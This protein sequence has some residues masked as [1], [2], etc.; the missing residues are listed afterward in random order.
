[1]TKFQIGKAGITSGVVEN[2]SVY[3]KKNKVARISALKS[4]ER[5]REKIKEI[6]DELCEKLPGN[7]K[8]TIVGFT[9]ILRR[10]GEVKR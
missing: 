10:V 4:S 9:I 2:L 7:Y 1:M 8:Y 6:A 3:F 5:D